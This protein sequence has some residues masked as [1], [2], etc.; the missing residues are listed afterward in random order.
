MFDV[1]NSQGWENVHRE[2][3]KEFFSLSILGM[4]PGSCV[5]Q[6]STPQYFQ[7][8]YVLE[9]GLDISFQMALSSFEGAILLPQPI[10]QQRLQ[11][12]VTKSIKATHI[13]Q[14]QLSTYHLVHVHWE[15][16]CSICN[17]N[18]VGLKQFKKYIV[19]R[20]FFF[21]RMLVNI[22]LGQDINGNGGTM[23]ISTSGLQ[24]YH[25]MLL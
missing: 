24:I 11:V 17:R 16:L 18:E 7:G 6:A 22:M 3:T 23:I 20:S 21:D 15:I 8:S 25:K 1:Q 5:C 10:E 19:K 12:D 2:H 9:Q 4:N 14:C 13:F